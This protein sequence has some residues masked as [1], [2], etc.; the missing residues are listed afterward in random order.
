MQI[1]LQHKQ[2]DL[3]SGGLNHGSS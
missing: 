3:V 1:M 2:L